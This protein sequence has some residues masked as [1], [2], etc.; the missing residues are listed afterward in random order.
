MEDIWGQQIHLRHYIKELT[1]R[2]KNCK[3]D[4]IQIKMPI[5]PGVSLTKW[6]Y[7]AQTGHGVGGCLQYLFLTKDCYPKYVNNSFSTIIKKIERMIRIM[8]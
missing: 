7:M 3:L 1:K 5:H 6:I 8:D 4:F 2:E